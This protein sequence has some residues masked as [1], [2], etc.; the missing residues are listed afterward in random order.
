AS[1]L[2][3]ALTRLRGNPGP[4]I[5]AA[6]VTVPVVGGA[7]ATPEVAGAGVAE[8]PPEA[9]ATLPAVEDPATGVL[10]PAAAGVGALFFF[11]FIIKNR[12]TT[13]TRTPTTAICTTG[14]L[15]R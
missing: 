2:F 13:T 14:L 8:T 1:P 12:P 7:A 11:R 3:Q 15:F 5:R 10:D 4:G 6:G 9:A